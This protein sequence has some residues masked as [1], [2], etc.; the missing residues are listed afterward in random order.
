MMLRG[1]EIL[2]ETLHTSEFIV[3]CRPSLEVSLTGLQTILGT[4]QIM[5]QQT[6]HIHYGVLDQQAARSPQ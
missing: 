6:T 4:S 5:L 3:Y 1:R 2:G